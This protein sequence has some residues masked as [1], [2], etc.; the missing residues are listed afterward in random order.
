MNL[1][2]TLI[3]LGMVVAM[4]PSGLTRDEQRAWFAQQDRIAAEA[5]AD[6]QDEFAHAAGRTPQYRILIPVD[7][8]AAV[9]QRR[10]LAECLD[11]KSVEECLGETK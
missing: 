2:R 7:H 8:A 10:K 11:R 4:M 3:R 1:L 6:Q 5:Y 9:Q